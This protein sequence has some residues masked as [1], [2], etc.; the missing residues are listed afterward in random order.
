MAWM[1]TSDGFNRAAE[2]CPFIGAPSIVISK[3]KQAFV[4]TYKS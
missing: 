1:P 4:Q 2:R 3:L